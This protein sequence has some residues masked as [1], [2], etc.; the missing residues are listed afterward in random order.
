MK[1]DKTYAT[2]GRTFVGVVVSARA[3]KTVTV[4]WERRTYV[5]KYER[6]KKD[7]TRVKA[8]NPE[9]VDA[10]E[11]DVVEVR[12]CRPISKTKHFI[13]T[14][15]MGQDYEALDKSKRVHDLTKKDKTGE[16]A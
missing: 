6:Y 13:I 10:K 4:E 11:G 3:Q 15:K 2:R 7:R 14:K 5:P 16:S 12:E 8:H 1:M 9:A